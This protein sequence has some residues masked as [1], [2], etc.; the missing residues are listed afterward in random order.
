LNEEFN[1]IWTHNVKTNYDEGKGTPEEKAIYA[2]IAKQWNYSPNASKEMTAKSALDRFINCDHVYETIPIFQDHVCTK[3]EMWINLIQCYLVL[4]VF[5]YF[6]SSAMSRWANYVQKK[7]DEKKVKFFYF[8][9]LININR[10]EN[11]INFW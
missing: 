8:F 4:S 5:V 1:D 11:K 3:G 6:L 7:I 10:T 9:K 2:K